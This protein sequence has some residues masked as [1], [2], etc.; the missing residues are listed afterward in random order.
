MGTCGV[1]CGDMWGDMWGHVRLHVGTRGVTCGDMWG[2]M[3]SVNRKT[4]THFKLQHM[5]HMSHMFTT[6]SPHVPHM[7]P[8]CLPHVHHMSR[9]AQILE[10][11]AD[12]W[13]TGRVDGNKGVFPASFVELIQKPKT[14]DERKKLLK[15]FNQGTLGGQWCER[16]W[17]AVLCCVCVQ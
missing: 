10:Q 17:C 2:Y 11:S 1:T 16:M 12:G 14:K 4:A 9:P 5:S 3:L 13:W 7:F 8:S 6:C 15:R